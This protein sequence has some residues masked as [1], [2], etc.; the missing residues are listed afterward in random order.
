M[1]WDIQAGKEEDSWATQVYSYQNI[2]NIL[3]K[4]GK[5]VLL[6]PAHKFLYNCIDEAIGHF[7]RYT[8][9]AIE[10]K[11]AQTNFKIG[12]LFYFNFLAIFG[13]YLQGNILKKTQVG[14]GKM[15]L[16]DSLVPIMRFVE[17]YIILRKLGISLTVILEKK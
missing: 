1:T 16:F 11:I 7:R 12:S 6:V 15:K 8:R 4:N 5:F 13:W 14:T 3:K 10:S 17:R 9:K 2:Y